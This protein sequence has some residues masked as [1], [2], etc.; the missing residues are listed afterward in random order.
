MA[1][2]LLWLR[3]D[4]RLHDHAALDAAVRL[5]RRGAEPARLLAVAVVDPR[6]Q[7]DAGYGFPKA[8]PFRA[9]FRAEALADLRAGL[10]RLGGELV[11]RR[12]RPADVLPPLAVAHG[13]A[14]V[15][16]H[17]EPMREEADD[18][19]AVRQALP[20]GVPL[21][22]L[23]GHTLLHPDDLPF[24]VA[25]LPA[26]FTSFRRAVE[27]RWR[28]RDEIAPPAAVP[29]P[30][31]GVEPGA[32][33]G[34]ADLGLDDRAP[35]TRAAPAF[36]GG[37]TA[38]LAR[39]DAYVWQRDRLR[40]YKETRNGMLG[41]D[42]ASRVSPWLAHGCLSPRRVHAEVRRYEAERVRNESTYWLV[43]ELLWRDYFRFYGA[44]QGDRLFVRAAPDARTLHRPVFDAWR[45]GR[46]G[47]PL[48]DAGMR[49]LRATGFL[50]NRARQN[51]ASFFAKTLGQ[52][53]RAGAAWFEHLLVDYD[54]TSNWGNWAYVAGVG[55]DP[56]DRAFNVTLQAERYDPDGA[57]LRHWLPE[58]SALPPGL[59]H[60]PFRLSAMEQ[61]MHGVRL[62]VDYPNP[63]VPPPAAAG[64]P[65]RRTKSR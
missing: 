13:V 65:R 54:V 10:R 22:T 37:E 53:W 31:P 17:A 40:T 19:A 25:D 4:L 62:G 20:P 55:T 50:S 46:T 16:A 11:V 2:T 58:L 45:E 39:L 24:D 41:E 12:G 30:P 35:D 32:I 9:R 51:V 26:V 28:V 34:P 64:A 8:G 63:V 15:L 6:E 23:W 33:P 49:E 18:E 29:P 52:D 3:N 1:T 56:R 43:F 57:Y 27:D 42:D 14:A 59:I 36:M 38:A 5:A 61:Q 60:A 47:Y 44:Q 21:H 48:V 7:H